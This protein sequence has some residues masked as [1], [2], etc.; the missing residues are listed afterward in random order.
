M[1]TTETPTEILFGN[2]AVNVVLRIDGEGCVYFHDI[3]PVDAA[4]REQGT[5]HFASS[6]TPLCEVR[7]SGEGNKQSK[8]SKAL[9]GSYVGTRLQYR[10]HAVQTDGGGQARKTLDVVL[11]DAQTGITVTSHLVLFDG[12]PVLRSSATVRNDGARDVVVTQVS[13]LVIGGLTRSRE[14]WADFTVSYATNTW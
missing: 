14:W 3:L 13:S 7:L 5:P 1:A 8:T 11:H 6:A 12:L 4:P 10:S 2:E 9:I